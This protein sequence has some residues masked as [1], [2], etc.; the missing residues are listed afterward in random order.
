MR[1]V[2]TTTR[3]MGEKRKHEN[4]KGDGNRFGALVFMFDNLVIRHS[5][6]NGKLWCR[7]FIISTIYRV[8]LMLIRNYVI[9]HEHTFDMFKFEQIVIPHGANRL[10]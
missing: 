7:T 5:A 4:K 8:V 3:N 9:R 2:P 6:K 1:N 10:N